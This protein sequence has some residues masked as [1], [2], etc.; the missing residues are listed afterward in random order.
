MFIWSCAIY[1]FYKNTQK[2]II[3][4]DLVKT[5]QQ[6]NKMYGWLLVPELYKIQ[7]NDAV[8]DFQHTFQTTCYRRDL[9]NK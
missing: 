8:Q 2:L 9:K 4:L 3:S 5:G 1:S 6:S 7:I